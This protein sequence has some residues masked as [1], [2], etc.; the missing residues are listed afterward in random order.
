MAIDNDKQIIEEKI[1][2]YQKATTV[3]EYQ[4]AIAALNKYHDPIIARELWAGLISKERNDFPL[5]AFFA[6]VSA[7]ESYDKNPKILD[8]FIQRWKRDYEEKI[9]NDL[10]LHRAIEVIHIIINEAF[11]TY[12]ND[13]A[14]NEV[15]VQFLEKK[16]IRNNDAGIYKT[17]D[18]F[19]FF[20][21]K[22]GLDAPEKLM[23]GL[24]NIIAKYFE[25]QISNGKYYKE[26]LA[27]IDFFTD[28]TGKEKALQIAAK[29]EKKFKSELFVTF[30]G[31]YATN[32][33]KGEV[34]ARTAIPFAYSGEYKEKELRIKGIEEI[35]IRLG[36]KPSNVLFNIEAQEM[37]EEI[38]VDGIKKFLENKETFQLSSSNGKEVMGKLPPV[39]PA[40]VI[41]T[42]NRIS[43]ILNARY[44][45]SYILKADCTFVLFGRT[46]SETSQG[47]DRIDGVILE[48]QNNHEEI[49]SNV[50]GKT[51]QENLLNSIE[52]IVSDIS[53]EVKKLDSEKSSLMQEFLKEEKVMDAE[54]FLGFS[55]EKEREIVRKSMCEKREKCVDGKENEI[56]S[57]FK[58][59]FKK[60][61]IETID[62]IDSLTTL[63]HLVSKKDMVDR[64]SQ[65]KGVLAP[66][67]KIIKEV[68]LKHH[69]C[70]QV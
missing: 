38:K 6:T 16:V 43:C 13:E 47:C 35:V 48:L 12:R 37:A 27:Y 7:L 21:R 60:R 42:D 64:L 25:L 17:I 15:L 63:D 9:L 20:P 1:E 18:A 51:V 39:I 32:S 70:S 11:K 46:I 29:I 3:M 30:P 65:I 19:K 44:A 52:S 61:A 69:N 28:N 10:T 22:I 54:L 50:V 14:L 55:G 68:I 36:G 26:I 8:V 56:I 5:V 45:E 40:F 2:A 4:K 62:N 41:T 34:Y 57:A 24:V 67:A 33:K 66:P 23:Q 49:L 53:V 58:L 59:S 31:E